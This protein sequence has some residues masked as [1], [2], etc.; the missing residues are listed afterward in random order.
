MSLLEINKA[1]IRIG[2][3]F[4]YIAYEI[5]LYKQKIYKKFVFI[6]NFITQHS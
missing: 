3:E 6:Q 4:Q 5:I 1:A 2:K